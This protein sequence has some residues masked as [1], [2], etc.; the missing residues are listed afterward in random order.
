MKHLISSSNFGE[1]N[2]TH[3]VVGISWGT[4]TALSMA[5]NYT[6]NDSQTALAEKQLQHVCDKFKKLSIENDSNEF[7]A[8]D[9]IFEN[10]DGL[11]LNIYADLTPEGLKI[12]TNLKEAKEYFN[13]MAQSYANFKGTPMELILL[14]LN[15]VQRVFG[16]QQN[17]AGNRISN[18]IEMPTIK[19][20]EQL[21]DIIYQSSA[22][23][24]NLVKLC[25]ENEG[26]F[27]EED[28]N[29]VK[30]YANKFESGVNEMRG[31]LAVL[32]Q[33]VSSFSCR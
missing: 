27:A 23:F 1:L 7:V 2:G 13:Q 25:T 6:I 20:L 5:Y 9:I 17:F 32:V 18:N 33:N 19:R 3:V 29:E 26:F 16:L 10:G 8:D 14:P 30:N 24:E 15:I 31:E 22:N 4:N 12:P 21:F 28:K 11:M